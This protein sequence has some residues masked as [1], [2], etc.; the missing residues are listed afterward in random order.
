MAG[1]PRLKDEKIVLLSNRHLALEK[2]LNQLLYNAAQ[3]KQETG[4]EPALRNSEQDKGYPAWSDLYARDVV[5]RQSYALGSKLTDTLLE[6][7]PPG[8]VSDPAFDFGVRESAIDLVGVLSQQDAAK[9]TR[10][11]Q[12]VAELLGNFGAH[13]RNTVRGILK[14]SISK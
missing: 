13:S 7:L 12:A 11:D 10:L 6:T 9:R 14:A 3:A 5:S 8:Y 4:L 1:F 2:Y